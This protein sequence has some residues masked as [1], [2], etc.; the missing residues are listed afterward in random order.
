[1]SA[2]LH[3]TR[4]ALDNVAALVLSLKLAIQSA[5]IAGIDDSEIAA[6]I[7]RAHQSMQDP[8]HYVPKDSPVYALACTAWKLR[9]Q[10]L[11]VLLGLL[12]D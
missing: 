9:T 2:Y 12:E 8:R 7:E 4:R 5:R 3:E 1:M 11:S 10:P 6:V